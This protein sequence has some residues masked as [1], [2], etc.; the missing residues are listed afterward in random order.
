MP[1]LSWKNEYSV[2]IKEIDDQH[3]KL[4]EMINEL[5]DAMVAKKAKEVLGS[6][7]GKLV[8]YAATHFANEE[9]LMQ[10]NGYPE[11]AAHKEKHEKMTAKVL[12]LQKDWQAGKATLGIEVSQ[13]LRDWLDKHILG[14]DKNYGPFLNSKGIK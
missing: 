3:K 5:H 12:S 8:N 9:K 10:A 13:F 14:T 4:V 6:V 1:L 7:L 2:N 11:F